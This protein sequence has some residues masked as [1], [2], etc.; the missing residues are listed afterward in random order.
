MKKIFIFTLILLLISK[1]VYAQKSF[2]DINNHWAREYIED[3]S[4]QNIIL[5]YN[6]GTFKPDR[7][8]LKSEAYAIINRIF[9]LKETK[10]LSFKNVSSKDWYYFDIQKAV[11][12]GYLKDGNFFY[13]EPIK[14]SEVT[15]ILG[16]LYNLKDNEK[17][18]NFFK[19]ISNLSDEEKTSIGALVKSGIVKGY[20]NYEFKPNEKISRAEFSKI[21]SMCIK[22]YGRNISKNIAIQQD[23][24]NVL[25]AKLMDSISQ[26]ESINSSNYTKESVENLKS[27]TLSANRILRDGEATEEQLNIA[28]KYV[29]DAIKSLVLIIKEPTLT[30][31]ALD[32]SNNILP[33]SLLIND[34]PFEN[35]GHLKPG[36]YLVKISSPNMNSTNTY[37]TID[38]E[39]K[40]ITV[41]LTNS[42]TQ[43]FNLTLSEGLESPM[44]YS[45]Y[46]NE[47]VLIKILIP[48][49]M[50]IDTFTVNGSPKKVLD[51]EFRFLITTNTHIEVTF[52]PIY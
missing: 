44:G 17:N 9:D 32:N 14:R 47:R 34:M 15:K 26:A 22:V 38:N 7:E 51:N 37:V 23:N 13:N 20:E 46:K 28:I 50:Q 12:A 45:F 3:I 39:D 18:Y 21:I 19:D 29:N 25:R 41:Y 11:S 43:K 31:T 52:K 27:I 5:G 49:G 36:K 24:K 30:I 40:N 2:K 1:N 16:Y 35:G 42:A 8:I 4:Q 10:N 33:V 6:D 48:A